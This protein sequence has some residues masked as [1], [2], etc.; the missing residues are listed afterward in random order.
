MYKI[1]ATFAGS[2]SYYSSDAETHIAVGSGSVAPVVTPPP[3]SS[4]PAAAFSTSTTLYIVI[5][6][7]ILVAII[8]VAITLKRRK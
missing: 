8:A 1:T 7:V 5:S 4:P 6:V 3:A 2:N